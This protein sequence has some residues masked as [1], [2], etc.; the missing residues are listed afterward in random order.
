M[1]YYILRRTAAHRF[2]PTESDRHD[3]YRTELLVVVVV[4]VVQVPNTA[5]NNMIKSI[6]V[7]PYRRCWNECLYTDY[8][9]N[10]MRF[11]PVDIIG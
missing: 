11:L 2:S 6:F 4:I 1:L 8:N 7:S 10:F 9:K 5:I 3:T